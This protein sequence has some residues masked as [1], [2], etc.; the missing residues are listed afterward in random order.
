MID[1]SS[2]IF[3]KS[4]NSTRNSDIPPRTGIIEKVG[5]REML[6]SLDSPVESL[7]LGNFDFI[8]EFTAKKQ[9]SSDSDLF[10]SVGAFFRPNYER[11]L[12][13]YSLI[14]KYDIN[15]Y[16]EIGWGRGYSCLCAAMA[17]TEKGSGTV[18]TIDPNLD[19]KQIQSLSAVLPKEWFENIKFYQSTSDK[20]FDEVKETYDMIYIDGDHRYEAVKNDWK[21]ASERSNKIVLFDDYHLP[22]KEQKDME[23]SSLVDSITDHD[24]KLIIMDRR[25]FFDDRRYPDE[26]IDYGQVLIVK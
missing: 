12:L 21:N 7:S 17:M 3:D 22:G 11:G 1:L 18:T 24:K 23:V 19:E 20:F 5:I 15:S 9:R 10:H 14:K 6:E 16:L 13:I 2:S 4:E 25:I 26:D 8:G